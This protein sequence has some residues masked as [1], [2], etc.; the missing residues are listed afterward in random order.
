[1][2]TFLHIS[3]THISHDAGYHEPMAP[4]WVPH[5]NRGVEALLAAVTQLPFTFDFILHTGDVCADPI[6]DNYRSARE[7]LGHFPG[8]MLLLAG[9]HDSVDLM[10]NLLHDGDQ[11]HVLGAS[12][13]TRKGY[14][15][16]TLDTNGEGDVH[17]PLL[18]VEQVASLADRLRETDGRPTVVAG[19]HPLI[20]TGVP[21]IDDEMRVQNGE[22]IQRLLADH[23][24]HIAAYLHGH[25]HQVS[26]TLAA[27]VAHISCPSTWSNLK[28]YP[29][30]RDAET[31][32]TTPGGFNVVMLRGTSAFVRHY[33]LPQ[34]A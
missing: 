13:W 23:P 4:R 31:D 22:V 29:G 21:W 18:G 15:L 20:K 1:M 14:D 27:G 32:V 25:I 26:N 3:D 28:G 10:R 16:V 24:G 9:N 8:P 5:P 34:P 6:A 2:L 30:M 19:H 11:F 12:R 7:L 33:S 17:A